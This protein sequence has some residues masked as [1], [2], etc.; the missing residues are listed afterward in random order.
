[1]TIIVDTNIIISA[2][3]NARGELFQILTDTYKDLDF[4][5][6]D[7]A[8]KEIVKHQTEICK[9]LKRSLLVFQNNLSVLLNHL[10]ILPDNDL[11]EINMQEAETLT[12]SIDIDDTIFV[13]FAIALDSLLWT[14]DM[15]LYKALRRKRFTNVILTKEL[16]QILKGL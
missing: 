14:G 10:I 15:K 9:K 1:M 11:S 16:K 6:P 13:A 2:S 4:A 3:L 8:L 5:T 12:A 7:F